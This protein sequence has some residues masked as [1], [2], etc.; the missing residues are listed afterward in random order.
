MMGAHEL[1]QGTAGVV[2][3]ERHFAELKRLD[4]LRDQV[5]DAERGE[6]GVRVH[7]GPVRAERQIGGDAPG[8]G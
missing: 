2:A 3:H 1:A 6:I 8:A 4:Q 7:R 5:R